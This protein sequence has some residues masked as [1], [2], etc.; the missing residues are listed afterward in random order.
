MRF[1]SVVLLLSITSATS[2]SPKKFKDESKKLPIKSKN[3]PAIIAIEIVDPNEN[4]TSKNSKR[5]IDS[6]LGYGYQAPPKF[7]VYKYSQ[8]D[9]PPYRGPQETFKPGTTFYSSVDNQGHVGGLSSYLPQGHEPQVPVIILRVF[10][11][12]L[13]DPSAV[14]HPNLPQTHPL[15]PVV[16]SIDVHALLM[17]YV[18]HQP[19]YQH[20]DGLLTH[21]NYPK[22]TH[23]RVIFH[24]NQ[25]AAPEHAY[26][27]VQVE[28]PE[29]QYAYSGGPNQDY[30]YDQGASL[31]QGY[32][33][34]TSPDVGYQQDDYQQD[35]TP[36][37]QENNNHYNYHAHQKRSKKNGLSRIRFDEIKDIIRLN[38]IK[39]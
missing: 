37:V 18:D 5:T 19:Q 14:L 3:S 36:P 30:Y 38:P 15:A 21:E 35:L 4:K 11:S 20:N 10:P 31:G 24:K 12:Q 28:T 29:M 34:P 22:D 1:I 8:H 2:K 7:Q 23:T 9:I 27:A 32:Y 26:S 16:N 13:A 6:S 17:K 39:A 33:Y 25:I